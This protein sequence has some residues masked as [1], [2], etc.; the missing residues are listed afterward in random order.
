MHFLFLLLPTVLVAVNAQNPTAAPTLFTPNPMEVDIC[1]GV[2]CAIQA[3]NFF[4]QQ[5]IDLTVSNSAVTSPNYGS[6]AAVIAVDNA[7]KNNV[8]FFS[9]NNAAVTCSNSRALMYESQGT[10]SLPLSNVALTQIGPT[11]C[12]ANFSMAISTVD[13][14]KTL[15]FALA[16]DPS[17]AA[18]T[19]SLGISLSTPIIPGSRPVHIWVGEPDPATSSGILVS[20][21]IKI[22]AFPM[23]APG[24]LSTT[25]GLN[26]QL[27]QANDVVAPQCK[28]TPETAVIN[29]IDNTV[30]LQKMLTQ[31]EYWS[32]ANEFS[33]PNSVLTFLLKVV[34]TFD[35]CTYY[36]HHSYNP[37]LFNVFVQYTFTQGPFGLVIS[38]STTTMD[39]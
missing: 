3:Y 8:I 22:N 20:L 2:A 6:L 25:T 4:T 35:G 18:T 21:N 17:M 12:L 14:Q 28:F 32:C 19:P 13:L 34:P 10:D 31:T 23:I 37:Y 7:V 24:C 11:S 5:S 15:H 36:E 26:L 30:F 16:V 38:Q 29:T 39:I 9:E 1:G 33:F 27:L